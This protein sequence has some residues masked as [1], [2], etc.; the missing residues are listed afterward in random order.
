M[1]HVP[2]VA[3]GWVIAEP[4]PKI[5]R[6]ATEMARRKVL[7]I[8]RQ[9]FP[10]FLWTMPIVRRQKLARQRVMEAVT[11][12]D[13][14]S[15]ERERG[16]WDFA[17]VITEAD[18]KSYY[19]ESSLGAP[20]QSL[21]VA[22]ASTARLD[23]ALT[24]P[25][26]TP[27]DRAETLANRLAVLVLH[28]FGH[29]N[30]LEHAPAPT[31]YMHDVHSVADLD[32]SRSF[33][34]ASRDQLQRALEDVADVRLEEAEGRSSVVKF[35]LKSMWHNRM[36]I[37][38]A[39]GESEPWKFP[40]YFNRLTTAA[41]ST[42]VILMITAEAWELGLSRPPEVV[43]GLSLAAL[44][45]A[46]HYVIRRQHLFGKLRR[47]RLT[48]RQVIVRLSLTIAVVLGMMTTYLLLFGIT[49]TAAH[50]IFGKEL[51]ASWS[52]AITTD[53]RI[54][55]YLTLAGLFSALGIIVG[56]LGATFEA[57]GYFRHVA[58]VDEET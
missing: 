6:R 42:L 36:E 45:S 43:I 40:Y 14:G 16:G 35:F 26:V 18:L 44:V 57:K 10:D 39:I 28:L 2:A 22:V 29:L 56:A 19:R 53:L 51:V 13:A 58:Y 30:D 47:D 23:P 21:G 25:D 4:M 33:A 9:A 17:V 15:D 3:V 52:P 11:L 27:D 7:A 38:R 34:D 55:N 32:S 5:D 48:E 8:L 49:L 1:Q 37:I 31:A 41:G 12:L 54:Q 46:S 24:N 50:T 20:S